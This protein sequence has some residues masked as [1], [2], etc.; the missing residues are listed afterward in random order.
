MNI[1]INVQA[2]FQKEEVLCL[3]LGLDV[4]GTY[5]GGRRNL[6]EGGFLGYQF[7]GRILGNKD[8]KILGYWDIL[9]LV[10]SQALVY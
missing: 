2:K 4:N 6:E 9:I 10:L 3:V 1:L 8:T 7:P 5:E